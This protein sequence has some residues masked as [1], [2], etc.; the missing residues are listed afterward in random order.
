[1]EENI[2]LTI[3]QQKQEATFGDGIW[4]RGSEVVQET[5]AIGFPCKSLF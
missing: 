5:E 3:N 4:H 2:K 1:M